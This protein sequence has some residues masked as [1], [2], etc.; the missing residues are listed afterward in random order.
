MYSCMDQLEHDVLAIRSPGFE[1]A[2]SEAACI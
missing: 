1:R 2:R